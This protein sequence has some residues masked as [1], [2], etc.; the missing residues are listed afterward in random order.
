MRSKM[1]D[2]ASE[3]ARLEEEIDAWG[4]AVPW[5]CGGSFS[6]ALRS[7]SQRMFAIAAMI[8]R[9]ARDRFLL[10]RAVVEL[11]VLRRAGYAVSQ[12]RN[13]CEIWQAFL[14]VAHYGRA[15]R[16]DDVFAKAIE[17][18][19]GCLQDRLP[20][21]MPWDEVTPLV[22]VQVAE[23]VYENDPVARCCVGQLA[24]RASSSYRFALEVRA[25]L[26]RTQPIANARHLQRALVAAHGRIANVEACI[27]VVMQG[28][29]PRLGAH[30]PF[31][32]LG[33]DLVFMV[34][35]LFGGIK[36]AS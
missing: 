18:A 33:T 17:C 8:S 26:G 4:L 23:L 12:R 2:P 34:A 21:L 3:T 9:S 14:T 25:V 6:D 16:A 31:M 20:V 13:G 7:N 29:H 30:S 35:L 5:E 32:G 19:R 1:T 24:V 22:A 28:L 27:L 11:G 36:H 15:V 10:E